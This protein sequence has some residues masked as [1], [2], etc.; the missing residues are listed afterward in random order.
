[1]KNLNPIGIRCEFLN[2]WKMLESQVK[3]INWSKISC[4]LGETV[5]A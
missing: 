3:S 5:G 4:I 1:M 2:H